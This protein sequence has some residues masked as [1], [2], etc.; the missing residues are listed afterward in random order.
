MN[1]K[2]SPPHKHQNNF[3][4]PTSPDAFSSERRAFGR[5]MLVSLSTLAVAGCG[6]YANGRWQG[7]NTSI[8]PLIS[9]IRFIICTFSNCN[10]DSSINSVN[11]GQRL[12]GVTDARNMSGRNTPIHVRLNLKNMQTGALKEYDSDVLMIKPGVTALYLGLDTQVIQVI[13][14]GQYQAQAYLVSHDASID[15]TLIGTAPLAASPFV[16][17]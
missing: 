4:V 15:P 8:D 13:E 2:L 9:I 6:D 10:A 16:V 12:V 1:R 17:I 5:V 7:N 14:R 11:A 3:S